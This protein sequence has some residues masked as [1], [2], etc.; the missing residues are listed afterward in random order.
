MRHWGKSKDGG[1]GLARKIAMEVKTVNAAKKYF[2]SQEIKD[3]ESEITNARDDLNSYVK[4]KRDNITSNTMLFDK[5]ISE[6]TARRDASLEQAETFFTEEILRI[7]KAI[8]LVNQNKNEEVND[9]LNAYA[10]RQKV[11]NSILLNKLE[12]FFNDLQ[13]SLDLNPYNTAFETIEI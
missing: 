4:T 2:T 12:G 11:F 13:W 8:N 10:D 9:F 7:D 3:L 5:G 1:V 6:A